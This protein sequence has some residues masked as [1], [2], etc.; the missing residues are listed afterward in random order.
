MD[1]INNLQIASMKASEFNFTPPPYPVYIIRQP[2][3]SG[4]IEHPHVFLKYDGENDNAREHIARY[5]KAMS[6]WLTDDDVST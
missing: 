6:L 1:D 4:Y 5:M 2:Y 3:P